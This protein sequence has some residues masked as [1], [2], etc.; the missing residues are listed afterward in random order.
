L[1]FGEV[2]FRLHYFGRDGLSLDRYRPADYGHPWSNF[3]YDESTY[4]G[5]KPDSILYFR[6]RPFEVNSQGFRGKSYPF[7]KGTNVCRIVMAGASATIGTGLALDDILPSILEQ[8]LNQAGL[9][10]RV[11]VINL[12][13]GGSQFGEMLHV[14]R[15][16]GLRYHPDILMFLANESILPAGELKIQP[17]KVHRVNKSSLQLFT[18]GKYDFFASRFFF[19]NLITA[20]RAG[21]I[22]GAMDRPS[23]LQATDYTV[24]KDKNLD[25]TLKELED[26]RASGRV[27]LYLLRPITDLKNPDYGIAYRNKIKRLAA[28]FRMEVADTYSVDYDSYNEF[29]LILYPGDKHPS[30]M[31]QRIYADSIYPVLLKMIQG[32]EIA[33]RDK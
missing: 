14:L 27:L 18:S 5:L 22:G 25:A 28:A 9:P 8:R 19:A 1:A 17:R 6:G 23:L 11:E 32:E 31:A 26:M 21:E 15:H 30:A 7:E 16:V 12:S 24:R 20:F 2:Y 10:C 3:E 33:Y 13:I 4:T 29:D